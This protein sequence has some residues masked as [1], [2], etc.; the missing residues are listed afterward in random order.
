MRLERRKTR[1]PQIALLA[2]VLVGASA[3]W[4]AQPKGREKQ[5]K[6]VAVAVLTTPANAG[7]KETS[8]DAGPDYVIGADD[9]LAVNVWKEPDISRSVPVRPDGKIT[10]PLVG[11]TAASGLTPAQLRQ[12]IEKRLEAYISSPVVTVIV[13]EVKSQKFN[14]VGEVA[15]PGT[16]VLANPMTVLDAIAVAG[17]FREWAKVKDIYVLRLGADGVHER[18]PFNYRKVIK[19]RDFGQQNTQLKSRDTVVVP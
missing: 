7:V 16:Y 8:K 10:L 13:Q 6:S 19:G 2:A 4:A 12:N 1:A 18:I 3:T 5:G 15:R 17:G 11:D 14:I 9:V